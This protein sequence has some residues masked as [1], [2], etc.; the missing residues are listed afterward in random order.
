MQTI[1][2]RL[3]NII[4]NRQLTFANNPSGSALVNTVTALHSRSNYKM[5]PISIRPRLHE[6]G[7]KSNRDDF[8]STFEF[9]GYIRWDDEDTRNANKRSGVL[10]DGSYG[11]NTKIYFCCRDDRLI[12]HLNILVG[13]PKCSQMILMRY[14]GTCPR[15]LFGYHGH[16]TGFLQWDTEDSR[17][18]DRRVGVYPDGQKTFGSGIKIEFCSFT[19]GYS[20]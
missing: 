16:H 4:K 8:V 11:G 15:M 19:S 5:K 9:I 14:K 6:T 17:N 20:C 13:L 12:S 10:P 18:A 1:D 2:V 7:T 3:R